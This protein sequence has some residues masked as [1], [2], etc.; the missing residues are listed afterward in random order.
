MTLEEALQAVAGD[1]KQYRRDGSDGF[2]DICG[3]ATSAVITEIPVDGGAL[4]VTFV[5]TGAIDPVKVAD[6][7][8]KDLRG[9]LGLKVK[10]KDA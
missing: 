2:V 5:P 6:D 7:T 10:G 4:R 3:K 1:A 8:I 9:Q